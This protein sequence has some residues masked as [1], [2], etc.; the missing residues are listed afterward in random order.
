MSDVHSETGE[1]IESARRGNRQAWDT[2]VSL[3]QEPLESHIRQRVGPHLRRDVGLDDIYQDTLVQALRSMPTCRARDEAG[4]IRWL[5]GISEHVILNLARRQ[6]GNKLLFVEHETRSTEPAASRVLRREE[7]RDRLM[8][9]LDSLDPD[10]RTV[11]QLVR[12]EGLQI[13]EAARRM[14]RS[15]KS[16]MHL[17]SRA[18][19]KLQR[20][21][22]ETGSLSLP[23]EGFTNTRNEED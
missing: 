6:R 23:A 9:V 10:Y 22:G 3:C 11:V 7:R 8:V 20:T 16:V 2:L 1:L 12:L 14:N 18:L 17:L 4:L 5:K 21:F 15:P 19:R 13:K